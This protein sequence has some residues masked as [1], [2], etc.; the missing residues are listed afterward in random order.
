MWLAIFRLITQLLYVITYL[1][2]Y[3]LNEQTC[4]MQ[5][6]F[7]SIMPKQIGD[8][9]NVFTTVH[10]TIECNTNEIYQLK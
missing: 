8:C 7:Q 10:H 6:I 4:T 1:N 2:E 5:T 9:N 3:L